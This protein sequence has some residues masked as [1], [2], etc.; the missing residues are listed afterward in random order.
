MIA[1]ITYYLTHTEVVQLDSA[2]FYFHWYCNIILHFHLCTTLWDT[3]YGYNV[4]LNVHAQGCGRPGT[5]RQSNLILRLRNRRQVSVALGTR[6][7]WFQT[8]ELFY[9]DGYTNPIRSWEIKHS[10]N[11]WNKNRTTPVYLFSSKNRNKQNRKLQS[12]NYTFVQV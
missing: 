5:G 7:F 10:S 11:F 8:V 4:I 2:S 1:N 9:V 6:W 3:F 12:T